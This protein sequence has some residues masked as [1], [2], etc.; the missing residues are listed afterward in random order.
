MSFEAERVEIGIT[1]IKWLSLCIS[2]IRNQRHSYNTMNMPDDYIWMLLC[3]ERRRH[4]V[5]CQPFFILTLNKNTE[6]YIWVQKIAL[7]QLVKIV[8]TEVYGHWSVNLHIQAQN[9][10]CITS[11]VLVFNTWCSGRSLVIIICIP[12]IRIDLLHFSSKETYAVCSCL[13][14]I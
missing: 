9:T 10:F 2:E 5:S 12:L 8:I 4:S 14:V 11:V 6:N 1:L 3:S 13:K 7:N